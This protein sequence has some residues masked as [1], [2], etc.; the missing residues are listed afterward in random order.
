MLC[1]VSTG[2]KP[3]KRRGVSEEQ[4]PV[5]LNHLD[6]LQW[7]SHITGIRGLA[8]SCVGFQQVWGPWCHLASPTV[9]FLSYNV[10][11]ELQGCIC[12]DCPSRGFPDFTNREVTSVTGPQPGALAKHNGKHPGCTGSYWKHLSDGWSFRKKNSHMYTYLHTDT[13]E[14]LRAL[15]VPSAWFSWA[16][17]SI[18]SCTA[19]DPHC[20]PWPW[21][22]YALLSSGTPLGQALLWLH[23]HLSVMDAEELPH[24][25]WR[26][27]QRDAGNILV[28]L[29]LQSTL[30]PALCTEW[31]ARC[32]SSPRGTHRHSLPGSKPPLF[33]VAR[34]PIRL[35]Q[36]EDQA[37]KESKGPA[38][39]GQPHPH[40]NSQPH[41]PRWQIQLCYHRASWQLDS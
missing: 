33:T 36:T 40:T 26:V 20:S 41:H 38:P 17:G 10:S 15:K 29:L 32:K 31:N 28:N 11:V 2:A 35:Q 7:K 5:I 3:Q 12:I 4:V 16:G 14:S 22:R 6:H 9:C 37:E 8:G 27:G 30:T 39:L 34:F 23:H 21:G 25:I 24:D 18:P 13:K 1:H 19:P